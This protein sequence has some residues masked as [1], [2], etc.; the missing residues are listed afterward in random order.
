MEESVRK[1]SDCGPTVWGTSPELA[2][3]VWVAGTWTW[4]STDTLSCPDNYL[5]PTFKA[6][7][8]WAPQVACEGSWREGGRGGGRQWRVSVTQ[9]PDCPRAEL[10]VPSQR[11]GA[12]WDD[13]NRSWDV[14]RINKVVFLPTF[15]SQHLHN[16]PQSAPSLQSA[17]RFMSCHVWC[18]ERRHWLEIHMN[19]YFFDRLPSSALLGWFIWNVALMLQFW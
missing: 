8:T 13:W 11:E 4:Q 10:R 6:N 16:T 14:G 18:I 17:P 1:Q 5:C 9:G 19:I 7:S 15:L 3:W 12:R 2:L